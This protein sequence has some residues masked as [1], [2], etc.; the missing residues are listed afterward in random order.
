METGRFDDVRDIVGFD[1]SDTSKPHKVWTEGSEGMVAALWTMGD[2]AGARRYHAQTARLQS[3]S[4]GILY[5][6]DN[7][8]GWTTAPSVAATAWYVLNGLP[9]PRNPFNPGF[10]STR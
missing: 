4:G 7:N 10:R 5:A 8:S 9:T 2:E 1:E 3:E 6:T